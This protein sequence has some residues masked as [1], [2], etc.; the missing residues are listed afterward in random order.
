[1]DSRPR[2]ATRQRAVLV[3]RYYEG[4]GEAEIAEILDISRGTVKSHTAR[5][6]A[7]LRRRL[8]SEDRDTGAV[9]S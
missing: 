8:V 5:A 6:L 3:L 9:R 2:C 7:T 1:M 4:L